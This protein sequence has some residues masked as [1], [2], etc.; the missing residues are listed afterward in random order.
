MT[1]QQEKTRSTPSDPVRDPVTPSPL[2]DIGPQGGTAGR[3]MAGEESV[4]AA[5]DVE[6]TE[7]P[8]VARE[9]EVVGQQRGTSPLVGFGALLVLIV[10]VYLLYI[11]FT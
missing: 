11:L 1:V 5:K 6:P 2:S 3:T 7:S 10:V 4:Y 9:G 8:A